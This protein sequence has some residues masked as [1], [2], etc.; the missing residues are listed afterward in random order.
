MSFFSELTA[1]PWL[2]EQATAGGLNV[3]ALPPMNVGRTALKFFLGVA[4]VL[5]FMLIVAYAGRMA[6]EDWRPGPTPWLLWQNTIMLILSSM[7]LQWAHYSATSGDINGVRVGLFAAGAFTFGFLTG[8]VIAW[9][10]LGTSGYFEATNPAIAFFYMITGLHVLHLA[11]GVVGWT[12]ISSKVWSGARTAEVRESIALC[13]IYWHFLLVVWLVLFA[14]LFS[15]DNLDV[16][17]AI[18][19]IK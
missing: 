18:C 19:G 14:L 6:F 11:G 15:S 12:A 10:Q 3:R 9:Q 4:S 2:P 8:Q 5:F 17:L 13:T 7:A 1:K 16:L